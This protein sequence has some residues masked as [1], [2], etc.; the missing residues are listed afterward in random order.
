MKI[1]LPLRHLLISL[2]LTIAF[3]LVPAVTQQFGAPTA[4]AASDQMDIANTQTSKISP[5]DCDPL[6]VAS[7]ADDV[8]TCGTLRYALA[9]V[10]SN[11]TATNNIISFTLAPASRIVLN[12][13]LSVPVSTTLQGGCDQNGP[14][15]ILD[16]SGKQGPGLVLA[17]ADTLHGLKIGGFV[18]PEIQANSDGGNILQC[19]QAKGFATQLTIWQG[20]T[21]TATVNTN[22]GQTLSVTAKR[23]YGDPITNTSTTFT[24]NSGSTGASAAFAGGNSSTTVTTNANG[25]ATTSA[26]TANTIPGK[27]SVTATLSVAGLPSVVQTFNLTNL[28]GAPA[29]VNIVSG[30]GQSTKVGSSFSSALQIRVTDSYGNPS[31]GVSVSFASPGSGANATF[32]GGTH[33]ASATTNAGGYAT[34]PLLTANTVP[35]SYNVTASANGVGQAASFNLTNQ[36][37]SAA[38]ISVVSGSGQSANVGTTFTSALQASVKDA[39][40]NPISGVS[41]TFAAPGGGASGTFAPN[42]TSSVSAITNGNGVASTTNFTANMVAGTY[43]LIATL[44]SGGAL[45]AAFSL[46]NF[47]GPTTITA[48]V[49]NSQP[50]QNSAET[51]S[52]QLYVNGLPANGATMDTTWHYKTTTSFCSGTSGSAGIASCTKNV[53]H[54]SLGF[55]VVINVVMT[56]NGQTYTASTS[57]TP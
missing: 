55:T 6:I 54:A 32:S 26:L 16:G 42:S 37:G 25:N 28:P 17:G 40:G 7:T 14:Q 49:S 38:S 50:A 41:V 19:V 51:V 13:G 47:N 57:F 53:G 31:S 35:G 2:L 46:T 11:P 4:L 21:Q 48:Y 12:S 23:W 24:I 33:S 45:S 56:Y 1:L 39:Y 43:N 52:G 34:S 18:G 10:S 15:V 29:L 22:F 9:Y 44:T 27:F 36:V 3:V 5:T 8:N 30:S 20:N